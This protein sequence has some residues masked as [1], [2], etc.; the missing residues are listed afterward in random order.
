M[1]TFEEIELN[2]KNKFTDYMKSRNIELPKTL[3]Y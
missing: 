3:D 1:Y 2:N